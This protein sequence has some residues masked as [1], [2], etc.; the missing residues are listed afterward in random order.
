MPAED[1]TSVG[2]YVTVA[3]MVITALGGLGASVFAYLTNRDRTRFDSRMQLLEK[4]VE[5]CESE[6][7]A[8]H[9]KLVNAVAKADAASLLAAKL[10]GE[11]QGRDRDIKDM[12]AEIRELRDRLYGK[13]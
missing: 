6:R 8:D 5:E 2:T 10:Q 1:T 13:E 3:G 7:R 12:R 4:Q 11:A 9:E